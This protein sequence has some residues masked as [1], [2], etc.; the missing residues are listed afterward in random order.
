MTGQ[1]HVQISGNSII[2]LMFV[3]L[4]QVVVK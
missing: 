2:I 3:D 4:V 1:A